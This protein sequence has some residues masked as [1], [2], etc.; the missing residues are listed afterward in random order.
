MEINKET[1]DLI[2][3]IKN[4]AFPKPGDYFYVEHKGADRS[5]R[6]EV[7]RC[8]GCDT[9]LVV[10]TS[11]TEKCVSGPFKFLRQDW[12]FSPVSESVLNAFGICIP[13]DPTSDVEIIKE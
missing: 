3:K 6:D 11:P 1:T 4:V 5:W 7:F 13:S 12:N 10:S 8:S 9:R 2:N